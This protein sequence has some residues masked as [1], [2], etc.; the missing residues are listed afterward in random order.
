[1]FLLVGAGCKS[2]ATTDGFT[3]GTIAEEGSGLDIPVEVTSASPTSAASPDAS[4]PA[5]ATADD[6]SGQE[7]APATESS[8][9]PAPSAEQVTLVPFDQHPYDEV[10]RGT[11]WRFS[12]AALSADRYQYSFFNTDFPGFVVRHV[13]ELRDDGIY[14]LGDPE[15]PWSEPVVFMPF[16]TAGVGSSR[17]TCVTREGRSIVRDQTVTLVSNSADEIRYRVTSNEHTEWSDGPQTTSTIDDYVFDSSLGWLRAWR[18]TIRYDDDDGISGPFEYRY[19]R[20]P[21]DPGN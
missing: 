16:D 9:T 20:R 21:N 19:E 12:L 8:A 6:G 2:E 7:D 15:C 13:L 14:D 10:N 5:P 17:T 11:E 4:D 1:M 18:S 3:R